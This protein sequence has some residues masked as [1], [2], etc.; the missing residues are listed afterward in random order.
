MKNEYKNRMA[1]KIA[2]HY[3]ELEERIIQDIVRR[4][5]KTGE[6]TSTADW[7]IN[8]LKIIGYSSEDIEK[9]LKTTLNKSYPEMFELYDKVINWEYVR[10]K[11]LYEQVNA[12]YIPFEKNKH[13]N[14]AING[15]AQQSLED[16]ENITRSLGFYLDINGKKTMTPLSQVY[17]EHLDRACFDIVSGAFNYN[18]VLRRTVTQL[19]NSGLRTIDYASGWHNRVDVAAR[20]AVMTGL[21]QITGKITDY[22]AKK[23]GTEYF[24]VAW[25]A[26]ARPTHAVWQGKVWTKEQ[27]V[28]VCGLGTVTGLLG[29][30]CYHE[31]YPFFPGIS[32]RNWTDQWLE[33]K[34]QEE[35]KPKEFQG[36]EYT[37]YEAKQRQRQMETA[38][39]AQREKVRALQK[40]KADQDEILAHK[41]KYQG[42]LNEYAR[43]S[44]KMGFRQ[45]RERI[46]LD[47]RG[48]VAPDFRKFIAKSTGNDIIK[49][50]AINGA[51]TDKNDPLYTRRDAHANRYYESMRNSQKGTIVD[52]IS[53]NT[54]I[55]KKSISKIYDHVFI[56]EYELSGGKRKFDP[57][58][59]MAESFRRLREGKN[60]QKHDLIML[61]HERLEYELM[62]KLHLKYDEAHEITERK[63]NYQKAL[64]KFLKENNL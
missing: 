23:L 56:N 18:S 62:K 59:Y 8:R 46:Y 12:E 26:G 4:I 3:V 47:M 27:L 34:N 40:G 32:E 49:S 7:Q 2:A 38:M 19:T 37:V 11:D 39:R 64:N 52:R 60:I 55:S 45:E 36:K 58:Y 24:E 6:V 14:Q 20:R 1:N 53:K 41:M 31:Y 54:G 33:E 15:I 48:R 57:D 50:G 25:H 43:F 28:S 10:N 51:L 13:L 5:V 61:K 29:A 21:S 63:Y 30:N 22:N 16:L 42:Q 9:M 17:T 44:K 35:N